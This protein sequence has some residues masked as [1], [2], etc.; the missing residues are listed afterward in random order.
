[1]YVDKKAVS[2]V[3]R[4]CTGFTRKH[5]RLENLPRSFNLQHADLSLS[6]T[7][8]AATKVETESRRFRPATHT[9]DSW[10]CILELQIVMQIGVFRSNPSMARSQTI[11]AANATARCWRQTLCS[12][13]T[14]HA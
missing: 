6:V 10:T 7:L 3:K 4:G 1:M 2:A 8:L 13:A 5:T 14:D 12:Y 9:R 11:R